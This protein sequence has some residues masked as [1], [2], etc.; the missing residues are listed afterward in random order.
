MSYKNIGD[1]EVYERSQFMR[2]FRRTSKEDRISMT[3]ILQHLASCPVEEIFHFVN[4]DCLLLI[5]RCEEIFSQSKRCSISSGLDSSW[6][7][8]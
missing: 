4:G 2:H 1:P 6:H 8:Q 7:F 3:K 5:T